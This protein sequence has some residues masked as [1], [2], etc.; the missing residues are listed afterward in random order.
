M[1]QCNLHPGMILTEK[2]GPDGSAFW[3]HKTEDLA[4]FPKGW[5]NGKEPKSNYTPYMAQKAEEIRQILPQQ[6]PKSSTGYSRDPDEGKRIQWQHSQEMAIRWIE[7]GIKV[8]YV[9]KE[10]F[11]TKLVDKFTRHFFDDIENATEG[12]D[13][14]F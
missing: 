2:H 4:R 1:A 13:I 11:D 5:C 9:N 10:N 3:S 6:A 14:D 8:D 7:A 12:K